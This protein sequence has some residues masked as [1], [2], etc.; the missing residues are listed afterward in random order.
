MAQAVVKARRPG[1]TV[2]LVAGAAHVDRRQGVPQH[3][4]VDV[5]VRSLRLVAAPA[6][7]D[8]A[9]ASTDRYDVTWHTPPLPAKDYCADVRPSR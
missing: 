9:V 4:P 8:A 7:D 6:A 5:A 1:R 2:L 3:L